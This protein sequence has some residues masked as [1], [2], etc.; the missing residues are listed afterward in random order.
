MLEL[1]DDVRFLFVDQAQFIFH[2][3]T[4]HIGELKAMQ[5]GWDKKKWDRA[6]WMHSTYYHDRFP[7]RSSPVRL[8]PIP[9]TMMFV[10]T[11]LGLFRRNNSR[12]VG[13]LICLVRH[14]ISHCEWSSSLARPRHTWTSLK[15]FKIESIYQQNDFIQFNLVLSETFIQRLNLAEQIAKSSTFTS[16]FAQI[17]FNFRSIS[18]RTRQSIG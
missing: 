15:I 12:P 5:N 8:W 13:V 16:F 14:P 1:L 17:N 3:L 9:R 6:R 18:F 11:L 2:L 10:D 4:A 7:H